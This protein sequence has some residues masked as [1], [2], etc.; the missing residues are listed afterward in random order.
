[1]IEIALAK[2]YATALLNTT[3]EARRSDVLDSTLSIIALLTANEKTFQTLASP[4]MQKSVKEKL[5]TSILSKTGADASVQNFFKLLQQK[6]RLGILP[7]LTPVLSTLLH[8]VTNSVPA[9][10]ETA[11]EIS[12]DAKKKI[13]AT[14]QARTAKTV[15]ATYTVNPDLIGG[16]R[17]TLGGTV[18]DASLKNTLENLTEAI[19]DV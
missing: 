15:Q 5:L 9:T 18:I 19:Q 7:A 1:M 6:G 14:L 11:S 16:F 8:D 2:K 17:A 4:V 12:A 13:E 3:E 10:V